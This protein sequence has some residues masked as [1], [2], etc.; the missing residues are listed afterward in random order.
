MKFIYKT[1]YENEFI[2]KTR[3]WKWNEELFFKKVLYIKISMAIL[4]KVKNKSIRLFLTFS[5]NL[6]YENFVKKL[7]VIQV[8][9]PG[10]V[11]KVKENSFAR[12]HYHKNVWIL[13]DI[14]FLRATSW[15]TG[16]IRVPIFDILSWLCKIEFIIRNIE[17]LYWN[18]YFPYD[19]FVMW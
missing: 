19:T 15:N 11:S 4:Q 8:C 17:N 18:E 1:L 7:A 3:N 10:Y 13:Y 5:Q 6:F 2:R 16:E 14:K 9:K 12:S